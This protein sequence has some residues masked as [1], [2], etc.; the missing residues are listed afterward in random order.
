MLEDQTRAMC[1][2]MIATRNPGTCLALV[3]LRLAQPRPIVV[4]ISTH[5]AT[6]LREPTPGSK[7]R[8]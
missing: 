1:K 4:S 6:S 5:P 8:R 7:F 2:I 3:R